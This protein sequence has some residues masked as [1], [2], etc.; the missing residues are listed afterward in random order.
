VEYDPKL[1]SFQDLLT[2]YWVNVD[3][4]DAGGQ[5]CD[6]GE[7]YRTAI[8]VANPA[9]RQLAEA[10]LKEVQALFEG[11]IIVTP[12]LPRSK[13]F[14][15]E[16]AHQDY[17]IKNPLRYRYYRYGC[18]RDRR[19]DEVWEETGLRKRAAEFAPGH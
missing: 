3:P 11:E 15:V 16:E 10:S 1:I 4:F 13:F 12:I 18:G 19:L 6:R 2:I 14:P 8:F 17:Y 5:F 7:S 9:E